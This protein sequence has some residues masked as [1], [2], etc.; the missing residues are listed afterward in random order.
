M[1]RVEAYANKKEYTQLKPV[2]LYKWILKNYA[3][4]GDK[5]SSTPTAGV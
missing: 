5:R 3:K 1:S 2:A 4:P